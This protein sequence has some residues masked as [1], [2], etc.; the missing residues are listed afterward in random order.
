M[1]KA[2]IAMLC[3]HRKHLTPPRQQAYNQRHKC[4]PH[5][6]HNCVFQTSEPV[7]RVFFEIATTT[8]RFTYPGLKVE[9]A[10]YR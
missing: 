6:H 1:A 8:L 2:E 10:A 5:Y 9:Q 3:S 7:K 4:F